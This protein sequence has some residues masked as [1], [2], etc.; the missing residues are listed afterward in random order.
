MIE[1]QH[2]SSQSVTDQL[3]SALRF[4]IAGGV[5]RVG[6]KL[7]ATRKLAEQLGI[8]FHTVRKAYQQ[9]EREG[10][11]V[12]RKGSGYVICEAAPLDKSSR[13]EKGAVIMGGALREVIGLGLDEDEISYLVEEQMSLLDADEQPL[14]VMVASSFRELSIACAQ[15]FEMIYQREVGAITLDEIAEHSDADLLLVPFPSVKKV[16]SMNLRADV[17]GI[18]NDFGEDALAAA[19]RLLD[20][21]TLG[22]VTRYPDAVAPVMSVIRHETRFAGQVLAISTEEGNAYLSSLVRQSDLT[23]YT[24]G[25][26]RRIKPFLERAR[27]H[28]MMTMT[29]SESTLKRVR[30]L[31]P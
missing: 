12:A 16:V 30:S 9:L 26:H 20:H 13:M 2:H 28:V 8:S 24:A 21:E 22:L 7:P 3:I 6:E 17:V 31:I 10:L 15:H 18:A 11:V 19:A 14:K 27:R 25:A 1:I 5:Y 29:P 23:I 4:R